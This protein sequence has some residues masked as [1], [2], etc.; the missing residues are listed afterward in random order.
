MTKICWP[1]KTY[2][3]EMLEELVKDLSNFSKVIKNNYSYY[4]DEYLGAAKV[5]Q[6]VEILKKLTKKLK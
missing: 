2:T 1:D 6:A 5:D 3:P 4:E